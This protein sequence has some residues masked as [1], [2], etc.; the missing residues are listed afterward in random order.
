MLE[1][2]KDSQIDVIESREQ[3]QEDE[4]DSILAAQQRILEANIST[5]LEHTIRAE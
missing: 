1:D 3:R 2:Q 4:W 5:T